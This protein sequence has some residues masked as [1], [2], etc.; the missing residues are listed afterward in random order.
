VVPPT[1]NLDEPGEGCD[2]DYVPNT[3]REAQVESRCRTPSASAAPTAPWC[4]ARRPLSAGRARAPRRPI[5]AAQP[6]AA[7]RARRADLRRLADRDTAGPAPG[8]AGALS[9]ACSRAAAHGTAH[10]AGTCC[11]PPRRG[12][13]LGAT[14]SR[15]TRTG[16][17][18]AGGLPRPP[19]TPPGR[20]SHVRASDALPFRGG[21]ALLLGYELAAQVE[22]VLRLPARRGPAGGAGLRCPAAVL[23]DRAT[24]LRGVAETGAC[25]RCSTRCAATSQ[26]RRRCRRLPPGGPRALDEDPP[27][28]FL[29]GVER[30]LDYLRAGDVFQVNL[31]RGWRARFDAPRPIRRRCTSAAA[32]SQSRRRSP[33][34]CL[35]TTGRC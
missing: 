33:A 2:L 5:R 32:R 20:R 28:R 29:A 17:A 23:R 7:R 26:H 18:A 13:R 34:C 6:G 10:G 1:I 14:A 27:E 3:A 11:S 19:S 24:A 4:S 35:A 9:G 16:A 30:V 8:G 22:P 21:W 12:L 15:A 25:R 31:S